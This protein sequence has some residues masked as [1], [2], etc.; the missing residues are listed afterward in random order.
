MNEF[1][2][3][4]RNKIDSLIEKYSLLKKIRNFFSKGDRLFVLFLYL[5]SFGICIY[6]LIFN[7]FVIPI[8]GDFKLQEIPFYYN[9][10]DDWWESIRSGEFVMWDDSGFLGVNNIGANTFYYLWNI[11]FL[12]VLLVPRQFV[13]QAQAFMMMTKFVLAG[14]VMKKL[15]SYLNVKENSAKLVATAYA[16][17]GWMLYYLWFN[18]FMEIAVTFPLVLLG[19]EKVLREKRTFLLIVAL[20]LSALTNYFFFI[21]T[22]FCSVIYAIF[23]YFQN[24]KKYTKKERISV[25]CIGLACYITALLMSLLILIPAFT[26]VLQSSRTAVEEGSFTFNLLN[27]LDNMKNIILSSNMSLNDKITS[28]FASFKQLIEVCVKYNGEYPEKFYMYPLT[29][30]FFPPISCY[31]STLFN[32]TYYD[33]MNCS[34]F[35]YTPLMLMLIPSLILSVKEKRISHIIGFMGVLG[36]LFTPFAYYCFSGFTSVCY[37]RWQ[38]FVVAVSCIYIAI[39]FDR[40]KDMK[41]WYFILSGLI[42]LIGQALC[43]YYAFK[44]QGQ[45]GTSNLDERKIYAFIEMAYTFILLIYIVFRYKSHKFTLKL[46][47][48]LAIEA[49]VCGNVL[50]QWQ[51]TVLYDNLYG[52]YKDCRAETRLIQQLNKQDDSYFRILNSSADRDGSNLGMVEN[53]NG[54]GTFHSIYNYELQDF[55][56]WSRMSYNGSW[57]MGVH[58]KRA[59][60]DTFLN[61]K[62][63]ILDKNDNNIPFGYEEV[64]RDDETGTVVY[65]NENFVS[66][67]FSFDNILSSSYLTSWDY[68]DSINSFEAYSSYQG[69][70]LKN[71]NLY[72]RYGILSSE[73]GEKIAST[74]PSITFIENIDKD[75]NRT[76]DEVF[77]NDK[78]MYVVRFPNNKVMIKKA[79]WDQAVV[80]EMDGYAE[81]VPYTKEDAKHL[82]WNSEV[83]V[84]CTDYDIAKDAKTRGGAFVTVKARMGE[85]LEIYLYDKDGNELVHD[86]HMKHGYSKLYDRKYERGF[87][88]NDQVCSIKI[89]VKDTFDSEAVLVRPDVTYQYYD[90]YKANIDK[91]KEHPIENLKKYTNSFRFDTNY[92]NNRFVVLTI[93]YDSGWSLKNSNGN[94]MEVF[95]AQGGFIGFVSEV[96]QTTYTLS[97]ETPGLKY[98]ALGFLAGSM[99]FGALYIGIDLTYCDKKE[100][101]KQ[102]GFN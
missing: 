41:R 13:P 94:D 78:E 77:V 46:N 40:I 99:L 89:I 72:V 42:C 45:H 19:I 79:I 29:S 67:G 28:F 31:D 83:N 33:N 101:K 36:L 66:F 102:L 69:R 96:G 73:E 82:L 18:H 64:L 100:I 97:Y 27:A 34:L 25:I 37:G 30:Y 44:A 7:R 70:T 88:V 23:R 53:Y 15:L 75:E 50:L 38:L 59:N 84:D 39:N 56:N 92:E 6:T 2:L 58:E 26:V 87:Y 48:I 8:T 55:I 91:L 93:P 52:S 68:M 47:L 51:G 71:E 4:T 62:Y 80:G 9:G 90:T 95:K 63:Y 24:W 21:M 1:I 86:K 3:N 5:I 60:L 81:E 74:Y 17:S 20:I 76:D 10:Y 16:F 35:I 54:V 32:N 61:I 22:C 49:I 57:S 65:E 14:Y 11:F 85:N 12:P 43:I 98:G